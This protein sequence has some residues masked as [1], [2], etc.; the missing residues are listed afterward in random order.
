MYCGCEYFINSTNYQK[1]IVSIEMNKLELLVG[2]VHDI[3]FIAK[4][5]FLFW[6]LVFMGFFWFFFYSTSKYPC[7]YSSYH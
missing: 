6:F 3:H 1:C 4:F 2:V 7:T 5:F